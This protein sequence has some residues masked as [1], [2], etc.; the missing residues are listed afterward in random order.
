MCYHP[1][2]RSQQ[3]CEDC[4]LIDMA[5]CNIVVD[6]SKV[7]GEILSVNASQRITARETVRS[8][9]WACFQPFDGT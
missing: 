1:I 9:A 2:Q 3:P 5:K 7:L 4:A 6:Q 8:C